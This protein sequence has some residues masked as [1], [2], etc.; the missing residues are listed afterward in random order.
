MWARFSIVR[1]IINSRT[2]KA[3]LIYIISLIEKT[4]PRCEIPEFADLN[5]VPKLYKYHV[6]ETLLFTYESVPSFVFSPVAAHFSK[7]INKVDVKNVTMLAAGAGGP[8]YRLQ[9]TLA[10]NGIQ[11]KFTLSDLEPNSAPTLNRKNNQIHY[12]STPTDAIHYQ[13]S[14]HNELILMCGCF[15][16][17]SPAMAK[18]LL[19]NLKTQKLPVYIL[20]LSARTV[21][22]ILY[23]FLFW[24]IVF[25]VAP[26]TKPFRWSRIIFA[27]LLP[28]FSI[29]Y[30][31]DGLISCLKTYSKNEFLAIAHSS[32]DNDYNWELQDFKFLAG[33]IHIR[34]YVGYAT[35][36]S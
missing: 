23:Y 20:E 34:C 2:P 6:Q 18:S 3:V 8:A 31:A 4:I 28:I 9:K 29:M 35:K 17:F 14:S 33:L 32:N 12:I 11:L 24:P 5:C 1:T 22:H 21:P 25:L 26:F 30:V 15:H 19:Q 27:W 13:S 36:T 10:K 16:H 7:F